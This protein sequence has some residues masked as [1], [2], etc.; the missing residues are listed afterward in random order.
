[1]RDTTKDYDVVVDGI[2]CILLYKMPYSVAHLNDKLEHPPEDCNYCW[3]I[4]RKDNQKIYKAWMC[5]IKGVQNWTLHRENK[6]Y[7]KL[8]ASWNKLPFTL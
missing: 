3:F 4:K 2:E 5:D 8:K 1:M 6:D 7:E